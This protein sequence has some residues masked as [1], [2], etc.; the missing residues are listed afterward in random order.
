LDS[1]SFADSGALYLPT[2]VFIIRRR[3]FA[4]KPVFIAGLLS[5]QHALPR[6]RAR[7]LQRVQLIFFNIPT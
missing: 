4:G 7:A 5:K 3:I 2:Q 6:V 1:D